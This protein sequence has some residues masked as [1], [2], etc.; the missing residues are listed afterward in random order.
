MK[1]RAIDFYEFVGIVVPGS[2]LLV[3]VGYLLSAAKLAALLAPEA[4]GSFGVHVILAYVVG[5]LLQGLGNVIE[6]LYWRAWKGMP[7]DWPV[8]SPANPQ[9][10]GAKSAVLTLCGY[11]GPSNAT[12]GLAEWRVLVAR[13]RST[14]YV[15]G[16][17]SRLQFFNGN[18][19]MFR[20][21]LAAEAV[22]SLTAWW[23]TAGRTVLYPAIGLAILLTAYRMH[24]FG[25][26]YAQEL[27]ANAAELAEASKDRRPRE[28]S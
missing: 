19:A 11:T 12:L 18:Y 17:A 7:T 25:V 3:S 5:H 16:R 21:L 24:R 13:V 1:L 6:S 27:F 4:F 9:F 20:G 26:H 8:T 28:I 2:V 10:I 14:I 23:S 22:I 15:S